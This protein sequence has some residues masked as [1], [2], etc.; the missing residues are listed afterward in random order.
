[1][2]KK[3][4]YST[5]RVYKHNMVS[6]KTYGF[7]RYAH[8]RTP[9]MCNLRYK[10]NIVSERISNK[11]TLVVEELQYI[12]SEIAYN[13]RRKTGNVKNNSLRNS[14]GITD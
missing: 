3:E 11:I 8:K 4:S 10:S 2:D 5:R 9:T 1:M 12:M 13:N 14:C 7:E 6:R